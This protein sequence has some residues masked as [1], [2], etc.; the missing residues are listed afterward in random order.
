[1]NVLYVCM[2]IRIFNF[3]FTNCF[4]NK[5]KRKKGHSLTKILFKHTTNSIKEKNIDVIK[6]I[7]KI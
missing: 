6:I 2:S 4:N 3:K 1:M 7:Y 5:K